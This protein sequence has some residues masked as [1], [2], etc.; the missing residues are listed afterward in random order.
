MYMDLLIVK[1]AMYDG[2]DVWLKCNNIEM[3]LYL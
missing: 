1:S 3:S 2:H